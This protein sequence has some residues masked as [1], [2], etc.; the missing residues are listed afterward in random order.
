MS[1]PDHPAHADVDA[2]AARLPVYEPRPEQA[3]ALRSALLRAAEATPQPS[4][5]R[6]WWLAAPAACAAAALAL[7]SWRGEAPTSKTSASARA[8]APPSPAVLD[9]RRESVTM[10]EGIASFEVE[11]PLRIIAGDR[12]II[13]EP[14]AKVDAEV[15]DHR[16]RRVTVTAGWV[17]LAS[18]HQPPTLVTTRQSWTLDE[19]T[20]AASP[21]TA[22]AS[23]PLQP[24][25]TVAPT[26]AIGLTPR[27]APSAARPSPPS[28]APSAQPSVTTR[29]SS[30]D[31][32]RPRPSTVDPGASPPPSAPAAAPTPLVPASPSPTTEAATNAATDAAGAE[33]LFAQGLRLLTEKKAGDA[34][35]PL[36][37]ACAA[38]ASISED[39]CYWLAVAHLRSGARSGAAMDFSRFLARWPRSSRSGEATV[40]LGWLLLDGGDRE[41]ARLRFAAAVTDPSPAV[42]AAARKGLAATDR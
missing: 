24:A 29:P 33:P 30:G 12:D 17:V 21:A 25:S 35:A 19:P 14:G 42:R 10:R 11:T 4:Q 23:P 39:A 41:N 34:V 27:P 8:S 7:W 26:A 40:A 28:A 13:A 15:R 22:S 38:T 32:E 31:V 20:E 5:R 37:R 16:L 1:Q 9:Q 6:W 18:Q 3:A 2:L 36:Q